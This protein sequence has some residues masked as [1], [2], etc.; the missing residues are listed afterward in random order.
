MSDELAKLIARW[1]AAPADK[2][3]ALRDAVITRIREEEAAVLDARATVKYFLEPEAVSSSGGQPHPA[4]YYC[5]PVLDYFYRHPQDGES[6]PARL[7]VLLCGIVSPELG[8]ADLA[9]APGGLLRWQ[10]GIKRALSMLRTRKM[11]VFKAGAPGRLT[12]YGMRFYL[13]ARTQYVVR[14]N[15]S[16]GIITTNFRELLKQYHRVFG[17]RGKK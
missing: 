1:E 14:T 9:R 10:A 8:I 5:F 17:T 3:S 11:L 12:D 4:E 2:K 7:S 16:S 15:P 13:F 6:V